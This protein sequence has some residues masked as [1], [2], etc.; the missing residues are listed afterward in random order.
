MDIAYASLEESFPLQRN[1]PTCTVIRPS[2][3]RHG[4][5][6]LTADRPK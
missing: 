6:T 5:R 4:N 3:T 1:P 2:T